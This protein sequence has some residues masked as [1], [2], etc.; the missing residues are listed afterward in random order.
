MFRTLFRSLFAIL[1]LVACEKDITVE[2]PFTVPQL[3]VEGF[4]EPGLPPFVILTRTQG[5]FDPLDADAVAAGFV[6]DALVTVDDGDGPIALDLL[7]TTT[8]TEEQRALLAEVTGVDPNLIAQVELCIYST[9]NNSI[10]GAVGRT[11]HLRIEQGADVLTSV[12]TIPP[13]VPLDSL[14][15]QPRMLT[16]DDDSVGFLWGRIEDPAG[17]GN[18]Y[19]WYDRRISTRSGEDDEA[20]YRSGANNTFIDRYF[21]GGTYRFNTNGFRFPGDTVVVHFVSIGEAEYRF[22]RSY[23]ANVASGGDLLGTPQNAQSNI[24]GGLGIWAGRGVHTDTVVCQ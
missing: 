6:R 12:S 19:R 18:A 3:V 21:D 8:L 4:I 13:P 2:L 1:A 10:L 15:F 17:S 9:T 14:W 16:A 5:Y 22:Y 11:Y 7:C 24:Q 23:E 20:V